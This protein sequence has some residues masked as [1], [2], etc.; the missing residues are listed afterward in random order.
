MRLSLQN[1][2]I[3]LG[4][5]FAHL[6]LISALST[7]GPSRSVLPGTEAQAAVA[8]E[9]DAE[10][11]RLP[12]DIQAEEKVASAERVEVD[13]DSE[14]E[15][16]QKIEKMVEKEDVLDLPAR[17]RTDEVLLSPLRDPDPVA[18]RRP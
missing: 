6:F 4:V 9:Q 17:H 8:V 12:Q 5:T 15:V 1:V 3:L 11:Q 16:G 14:E 7:A 13:V 10:A 2:L 18:I